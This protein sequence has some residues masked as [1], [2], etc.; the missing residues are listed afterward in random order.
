MGLNR[1]RFNTTQQTDLKTIQAAVVSAGYQAFPLEEMNAGQD[2]EEKKSRQAETLDLKRKIWVGGIFS[3][4]LVLGVIPEILGINLF[5]IPAWLGNPWLQLILT[6][7]VLFWCGQDFFAGGW[8]AFKRHSANMDTLVALGTGVAYLYSFFA[9]IFPNILESQG[10]Q[11][12]GLL[13]SSRSCDYFGSFRQI[14]GKS[15][16]RTNFRSYS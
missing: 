3:I 7:P 4:L 10:V 6:T 1:R 9:T 5:F 16:Q 12:R 13:R 2:D 11:V 15:S 8:K 14:I